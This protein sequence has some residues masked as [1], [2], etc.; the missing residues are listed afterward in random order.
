MRLTGP[1]KK[2]LAKQEVAKEMFALAQVTELKQQEIVQVLMVMLP[3]QIQEVAVVRL[4]Q[5]L[6]EFLV[7][8]VLVVK[9]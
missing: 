4:Q 7:Q 3:Q 9:E 6:T 8:A 2:E 1:S 5:A